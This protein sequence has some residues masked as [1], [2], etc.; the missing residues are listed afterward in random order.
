MLVSGP[1]EA[2]GECRPLQASGPCVGISPAARYRDEQCILR[3]PARLFVF[4]DGTY[5]IT[6]PDG[7][8]LEFSAFTEM[9]AR[10]VRDGQSELDRLLDYA[11]E[12]HGPGVLEDDF[13]IIKMAL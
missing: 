12:V 2:A 11:R 1:C 7:S 10:P 5:E 9:L 3:S 4:S 8:M 6:R 13:T